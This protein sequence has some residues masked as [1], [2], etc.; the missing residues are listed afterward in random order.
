M[1]HQS[2]K[3]VSPAFHSWL[4]RFVAIKYSEFFS[5]FYSDNSLP[6]RILGGS[7]KWIV[8]PRQ[9][10]FCDRKVFLRS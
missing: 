3:S 5:V 6:A 9:S 8:F 2:P 1:K 4:E 10:L 7:Y